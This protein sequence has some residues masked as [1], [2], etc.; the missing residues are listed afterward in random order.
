MVVTDLEKSRNLKETSESQGIY[1]RSYGIYDRIPKLGE[2]CCLKFISAKLK[3]LILI[4]TIAVYK[5]LL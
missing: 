1:Q 5:M 2:F 3:I 4:R